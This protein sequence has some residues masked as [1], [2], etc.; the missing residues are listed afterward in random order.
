MKEEISK[1]DT[2]YSTL[3]LYDLTLNVDIHAKTDFHHNPEKQIVEKSITFLQQSEALNNQNH[4]EIE[5]IIPLL[6]IFN[7]GIY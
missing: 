4:I 5:T 2:S 3:N 1:I 7:W 6:D